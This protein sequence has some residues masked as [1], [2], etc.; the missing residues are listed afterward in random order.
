MKIGITLHPYGEKAAAGLGRYILNLS[1]ALTHANTQ[2]TYVFFIKG[3]YKSVPK[4]IVN[5]RHEVRFVKEKKLWLDT[6]LNKNSDIDVWVYYT[7]MMPFF[8]TPKRSIVVALDFAY[9]H[10]PARS[11]KEKLI[12]IIAKKL[13]G[14]ALKKADSVATISQ[15]TMDEVLRW[16]PHISSEKITPIMGGYPDLSKVPEED[17][18]FELPEN[19]F[20]S[21]GV[22]KQ[23]KNQLNIIKGFLRAK[24]QGLRSKLVVCG[25]GEGQYFEEIKRTINE[26]PY[27]NDVIMAGYA[28]DGQLVTAYKHASALVFPSKMEGFGIPILEAF[29]LGLPVITANTNS[30]SELAQD[31]AVQVNPDSVDE[32]AEAMISLE[33]PNVQEKL[34]ARGFERVKGF[35]WENTAKSLL[36]IIE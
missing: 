1:E 31:A 2:H 8:H 12:N 28:T 19:F 14:R 9:L 34:R 15:Y 7:P 5:T 32:I 20:L 36:D 29:S 21:V 24:E 22:I 16:F 3:E 11:I 30:V 26:S 25:K 27:G 4:F 18:S 33:K 35:S 6:A 10:Y 23:R 17:F 13:H